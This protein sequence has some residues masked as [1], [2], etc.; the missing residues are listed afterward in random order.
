M[1]GSFSEI[2]QD[3]LE[4]VQV[5]AGFLLTMLIFFGVSGKKHRWL[6][7]STTIS[8]ILQCLLII[9]FRGGLMVKLFA[10]LM[11]ISILSV[12]SIVTRRRK[13]EETG[14]SSAVGGSRG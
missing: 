8:M 2:R 7:Y 14:E 5:S 4:F 10:A 1:E 3:A 13:L 12:E 11:V 6:K 9:L